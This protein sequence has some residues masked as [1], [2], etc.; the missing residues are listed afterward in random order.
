MYLEQN[1]LML[2]SSKF[3][4]KWFVIGL[5]VRL[6]LAGIVTLLMRNDLEASML[7]LADIPTIFCL[8]VAERLVS[9]NFAVRLSG[10]H[11]YYIPMN[12]LG[13][14][15]WGFLFVLVRLIVAAARGKF[16]PAKNL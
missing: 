16:L 2:A 12:L 3:I 5:T 13:G 9:R 11:P 10:G 8:E 4:V 14:A 7:Y 1:C 15:L 6:G